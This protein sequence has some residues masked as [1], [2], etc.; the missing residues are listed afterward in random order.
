MVVYGVGGTLSKGIGFVLLPV[1]TRL[2]SPAEYG[3]L[4]LLLTI[5]GLLGVVLTL[6]LDASQ[7]FFFTRQGRHGLPAQRRVVTAVFQLRMCWGLVVSALSAVAS[8]VLN[9]AM[10]AGDLSTHHF[11]V[12]FGASFFGQVVRQSVEIFRL[13]FKP[14]RYLI[15]TS[16]HTVGTASVAIVL[17]ATLDLG[18]LGYFYGALAASIFAAVLGVILIRDYLDLRR[19]SARLWP[20]LLRFGA[21][22]MPAGIAMYAMNT[23]DRWFVSVLRGGEELGLYSAAAKFAVAIGLAA[24]VFRLAWWPQALHAMNNDEDRTIFRRVARYYLGAASAGVIVLTA[25]SGPLLSWLTPPPYHSGFPIVGVLAWHSVFYGFYLIAAAGMWKRERTLWSPVLIGSAGAVNALLNALLVPGLG[26]LGAAIATSA[27]F[28]AWIV[29]A[30]LVSERLWPVSYEF[31]LLATQAIVGITASALVLW[32][33]TRGYV[34]A[35]WG[36]TGTTV[37]GLL[38]T[39][40][41]SRAALAAVRRVLRQVATVARPGSSS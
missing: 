11:L 37:A 21:P 12:A 31:G 28:L 23:M 13:T 36:V 19:M 41:G 14:W 18:M 39:T 10:F 4:Q 5:T 22:L 24:Q 29:G 25:A 38:I 40:V 7:G 35:A 26:G 20:R 34:V 17:I 15:L 9:H 1:L 8:P 16:L 27:A 6:G 32:M 3:S 33:M 30:V 2:F